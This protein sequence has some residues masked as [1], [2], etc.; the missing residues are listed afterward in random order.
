MFG[1]AIIILLTFMLYL[2][3][4]ALRD[5]LDSFVPVCH[6]TTVTA[7]KDE[8]LEKLSAAGKPS[9]LDLYNMLVWGSLQHSG[10]RAIC[11]LI[12]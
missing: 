3:Q 12:D 8:K 2:G 4:N 5:Q 10:L 11:F 1:K 7:C 9:S 6:V